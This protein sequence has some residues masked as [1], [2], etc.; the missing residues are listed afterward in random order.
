MFENA[1]EIIKNNRDRKLSGEYNCIPWGLP[2]FEESS[3]IYGIQQGKYYLVTG[4]QKSGKSQIADHL[5]MYHPYRWLKHTNSDIKLKIIYFSLE[6]SVE[7]KLIQACANK[8]YIDSLGSIR[9]SPTDLKS[10][11]NALDQNILDK[12]IADTGYFEDFLTTIDFVKDIKNP[13]GII[14]YIEEYAKKNGTVIEKEITIDGERKKVFDRYIPNNPNEYVIIIVDHA[15]LLQQE[16]KEGVLL[17]TKQCI[18][19]LSSQYF[20]KIRNNYNYIPVLIQQQAAAQ[21]SVENEKNNR[22]R[23][24]S[25]G[26]AESKLPA[27]DVN[28][29]FG[30]F[31]PYRHKM[32]KY[33]NDYGEVG[34]DITKFKDNIRFLELVI[35]REGGAG[36][37]CPL[38]FDGAVNIF[39]ELPKATDITELNKV[40][41]YINKT[42]VIK[43]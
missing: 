35:S 25:D 24:T 38:F 39:N 27:R 3:G 19:L 22:L 4:N 41:N 42:I 8:L 29:M 7:E 18:E 10:I 28:F 37:I 16:K 12:I 5:F 20:I 34:Y 31:S 15:S 17:S 9:K 13:T 30:I 40:L 6:M 1:L 2:R 14:K 26:L 36:S 43:T 33:P 23:P 32:Q 11:K 21:E